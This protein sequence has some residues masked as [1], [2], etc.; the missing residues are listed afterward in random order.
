V[1]VACYWCGADISGPGEA[2]RIGAD[3]DGDEWQCTDSAWCAVRVENLLATE[4]EDDLYR[5][6]MRVRSRM[7]HIETVALTGGLL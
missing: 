2:D 7:R 1:F 5:D 3:P 4:D 6:W